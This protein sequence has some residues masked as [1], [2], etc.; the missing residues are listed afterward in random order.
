MTIAESDSTTASSETASPLSPSA[1]S[2]ASQAAVISSSTKGGAAVDAPGLGGELAALKL[3]L[4]QLQD[5]LPPDALRK[6][7]EALPSKGP[8]K[9]SPKVG[10]V[11]GIIPGN[12]RFG[13]SVL[14][15][16]LG[17]GNA[18]SERPGFNQQA[19]P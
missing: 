12:E 14:G 19:P 8:A 13:T 4:L 5:R 17:S 2:A 9:K 3:A 18:G 10:A 15:F 11:D 1:T 7:L 16:S 6:G